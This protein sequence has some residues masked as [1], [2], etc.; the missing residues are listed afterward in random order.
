MHFCALHPTI[1]CDFLLYR[2]PHSLFLLKSAKMYPQ[3]IINP[4]QWGF[5]SGWAPQAEGPSSQQPEPGSQME[6]KWRQ[7]PRQPQSMLLRPLP[8]ETVADLLSSSFPAKPIEFVA[9]F[10]NWRQAA[11]FLDSLSLFLEG[12]LSFPGIV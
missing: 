12:I 7:G 9:S 10:L 8:N 6:L 5:L 11:A 2:L 3:D 4:S 1:V